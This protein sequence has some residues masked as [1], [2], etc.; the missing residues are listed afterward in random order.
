MENHLAAAD[1]ERPPPLRVVALADEPTLTALAGRSVA[2]RRIREFADWTGQGR[3]LTTTGRLRLADARELIPAL[4]LAD[5]V[6]PRIGDRVFKTTS[7]GE[8]Y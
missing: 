5:V 8:L 2:V 6:D 1:N 7:S 4:G 3:A